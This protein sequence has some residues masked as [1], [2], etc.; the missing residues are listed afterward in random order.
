LGCAAL[1]DLVI[2]KGLSSIS[3][4][5]FE[6]CNSLQN[7]FFKFSESEMPRILIGENPEIDYVNIYFYSE[8][9]PTECGNFW[10]FDKNG[11]IKIWQK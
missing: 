6:G 2:G 10:Y 8:E 9:E 11:E 1:K 3:A 4:G 5:A 7:V